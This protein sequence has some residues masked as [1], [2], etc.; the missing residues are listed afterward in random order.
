VNYDDDWF[1]ID[2]KERLIILDDINPGITKVY[3]LIYEVPKETKRL[4]LEVNGLEFMLDKEYID[5]GL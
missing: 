1:Y 3:T 4:T 5:L 2:E